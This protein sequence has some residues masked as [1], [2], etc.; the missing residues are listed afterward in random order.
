MTGDAISDDRDA[1][2]FDRDALVGPDTIFGPLRTHTSA[3]AFDYGPAGKTGGDVKYSGVA[4]V[5]DYRILTRV[6][7]LV[8]GRVDLQVDGVVTRGTY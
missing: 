7:N 2:D 5:R 4:W 3:V 6:G 1:Y 8:T